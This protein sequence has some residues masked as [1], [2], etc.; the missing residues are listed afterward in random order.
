MIEYDTAGTTVTGGNKIISQALGRTG[1]FFI[2]SSPNTYLVLPPG[3]TATISAES[4]GATDASV[5][6]TWREEY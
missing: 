6:L 1:N 4:T 3:Y 5:S 2:Q